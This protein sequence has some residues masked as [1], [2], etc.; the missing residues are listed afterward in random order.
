MLCV[1]VHVV[2]SVVYVVVAVAVVVL[3]DVVCVVWCGAL[4]NR[5]VSMNHQEHKKHSKWNCVAANRPQHMHM[6]SL[7]AC[8]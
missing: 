1:V 5:R 4:K 6:Y 7:V 8:D 2:W 3:V